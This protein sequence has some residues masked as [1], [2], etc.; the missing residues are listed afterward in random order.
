MGGRSKGGHPRLYT[1]HP[2]PHPQGLGSIQVPTRKIIPFSIW[3]LAFSIFYFVQHSGPSTTP[4]AS[5]VATVSPRPVI[6][7]THGLHFLQRKDP[8]KRSDDDWASEGKGEERVFRIL[9]I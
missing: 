1:L 5:Y 9:R 7:V 3:H 6:A 8:E 4:T 2:F